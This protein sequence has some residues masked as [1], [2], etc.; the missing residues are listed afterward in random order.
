MQHFLATK[1]TTDYAALDE[2]QNNSQWIE[3]V[4]QV[5]KRL[6]GTL[7]EYA[8]LKLFVHAIVRMTYNQR[9]SSNQFSQGQLAIVTVLPDIHLPFSQQRLTLR[10]APPCFRHIDAANIPSE[11][12][13]ICIGRRTTPATVVGR[14]LQMGRRTQFP[15]RYHLTSTIHRI[16]GETVQLCATQI[17]EVDR[18]YRLWQKEQLTVLISRAQR[19]ADII[20]VGSRS[21]TK[22][23]IISIL[24]RSSRWDGIIDN[25]MSSLDVLC[26]P[27][28]REIRL[29]LHPF[30]P[31]Y[32]ELP[33]ASCGYVYLLASIPNSRVSFVGECID[34]KKALREHNTGYGDL[35]TKPTELH[36]W[37]VFAFVCGFEC[38]NPKLAEKRR[39]DFRQT[40]VL[41]MHAG[42]E[43][44]YLRIK[45]QVCDWNRRGLGVV[46]V[47]CGELQSAVS[48]VLPS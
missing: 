28:V 46:I 24:A 48:P 11:W 36:P 31:L 35:T 8:V 20:F 41:D 33:S 9:R 38:D 34:L 44:I 42:P 4:P 17:S 23:A 22:N 18:H 14:C 10:L 25:Y 12:P 2:V 40:L 13:E 15:V 5:T 45:E 30:L 29:E 16:Q 26:R 27:V 3:A 1:A 32:R 7:Y 47:K 37:G 19:C 43:L 39:K 6:D 21:Q